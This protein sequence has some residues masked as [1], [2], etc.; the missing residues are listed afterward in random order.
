MSES[1]NGNINL[2][3][4]SLDQLNNLKQQE[5]GRLQALTNRYSQL[6][7]AAARLN[8]SQVAVSEFSP[9]LEGK[10]VMI[11]LTGSLYVPG[12]I[13]DC[14]KLLVDIGTGFYVEKT[15]KDTKSF[16]ERKIK[17]VDANSENITT[18]IQVTRQN[19]Q[20]VTLAMQGK[21]VEI[22]A[23]QEGRMRQAI[24]AQES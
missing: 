1:D 6:R 18:V 7:A 4:M 16:L 21:L 19:I 23:R 22:R 24:D 9:A 8:A 13:K 10:E 3:T 2:D 5:E 14:N 11:P 20:Q 17:L 15:P 12:K